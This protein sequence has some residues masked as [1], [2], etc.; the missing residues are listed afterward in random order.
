M[1]AADPDRRNALDCWGAALA[2]GDVAE[3]DRL[4][5]QSRIDR[6]HVGSERLGTLSGQADPTAVDRDDR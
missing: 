4:V 5:R 2:R 1:N 3:V 6:L